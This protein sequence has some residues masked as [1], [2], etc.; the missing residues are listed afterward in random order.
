MTARVRTFPFYPMDFMTDDAVAMMSLAARGAY[1]TLLCRSWLSPTPGIIPNDDVLLARL[2][3]A[4]E[5]WPAL[6]E[7]VMRAFKR[8]G[9]TWVQERM[10]RERTCQ[11]VR[12]NR[13]LSGAKKTNRKRWGTKSLSR[14]PSHTALE[15]VHEPV[16]LPVEP[17]EIPKSPPLEDEHSQQHE[18]LSARLS[19]RL[20]GRLNVALDSK[21]LGSS[22]ASSSSKSSGLSKAEETKSTSP[23]PFDRFWAAYPLRQG[24]AKARASWAKHRP[25]IDAV[26]AAIETQKGWRRWLEG[27]IPLPATWLNQHRW[28]DEPEPTLKGTK[29]SPKPLSQKAVVPVEG[30]VEVGSQEWVLKEATKMLKTSLH[31]AGLDGS[32]WE[33]VDPVLREHYTSRRWPNPM[34]LVV[35]V[36]ED[37]RYRRIL[38][39]ANHVR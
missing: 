33:K 13:A 34:S 18:S 3:D 14:S 6:R 2:S 10:V 1:I 29:D 16:Q 32:A 20:S 25:P 17:L 35:T 9:G 37:M 23:C 36:G 21:T 27:F 38:V 30:G 31:Q 4:R 5:Q 19:G 8:R 28:E 39:E 22:K 12:Y 11:I 26:L 15:Q 7:E 24:K